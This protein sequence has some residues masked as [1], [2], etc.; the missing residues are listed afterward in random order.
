M[1][2][3]YITLIVDRCFDC[4]H[5][6]IDFERDEVCLIHDLEIDNPEIIAPFC[7]LPLVT[8]DDN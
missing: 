8:E 6:D 7:K 1:A 5:M 2:A 4:I 3:R